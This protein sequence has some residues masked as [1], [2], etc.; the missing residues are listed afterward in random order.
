[1]KHAFIKQLSILLT[2]VIV[3]LSAKAQSAANAKNQYAE[4][5]G[6]K[7]AYRSLGKGT[8]ILLANRMRGSLDTWDPLFLDELAKTNRVIYFDYPGIGYSTGVLPDNFSDV[9]KVVNE[10][11]KALK[12]D[13]VTMA[14]WSWGG[15]VSQ[16]M[17][18]EY[19]ERVAQAVL[20]GTNPPGD[21]EFPV[22]QR[23]VE[24]ALKPI[25]SLEDEEILFFEANSAQS[26][27]AAKASHERIYAREGVVDK[28]PAT[29][30]L[31]Q[32][33]LKG[34][35][36]FREDKENRKEQLTRTQIPMLIVCGDNDLSVPVQNWYPMIGKIPNGQL[37]VFPHS[38][39]GPQHEFPELSARYIAEFIKGTN[40]KQNSALSVK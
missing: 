20:I 1:M 25:N 38:G 7:I 19:P 33:Y 27:Q 39:H 14:G 9:A 11:A 17:V 30:E 16:T 37:V 15:Y 29:M 6:V 34:H 24:R 22:Q 32:M 13:K 10:F 28:I 18:L 4:I 3:S 8:P 12:L 5:N 23:W 36:K 35:E 31:F 40:L 26:R 2:L 21:A